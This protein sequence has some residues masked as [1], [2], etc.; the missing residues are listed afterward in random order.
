MRLAAQEGKSADP[1]MNPKLAS[2]IQ[3]ALRRNVPMATINNNLKK[4]KEN[5]SQLKKHELELKFM[6]KVFLIAKFVTENLAILTANIN[7]ILR[8]EKKA[9]QTNI[10]IMFNEIGIIQV[11]SPNQEFK[12][13]EE[14]EEKLTDD[15]IECDAQEV[16]EVDF[17]TKSATFTC[18]PDHI[19]RV[20]TT[21]LKHGYNI[22]YSEEI[23]LPLK[24]ITLDDDERKQYDAL[25]KRITQLEGFEKLYDNVEV[26]DE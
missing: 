20:K 15:A 13:S 14:F 19:D 1:S 12:S 25:L 18:N 8:K 2:L 5:P 16:E 10:R 4:F 23:C 24:T 9:V 26:E 3:E 22:E 17:A 7:T 6:G 11:S 21:L